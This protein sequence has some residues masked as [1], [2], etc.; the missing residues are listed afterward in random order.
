MHENITFPS[1]QLSITLDFNFFLSPPEKQSF[2][3]I[4]TITYKLMAVSYASCNPLPQ[5]LPPITC[6]LKTVA[7]LLGLRLIAHEMQECY[8]KRRNSHQKSLEVQAEILSKAT[9]NIYRMQLW[10]LSR[11]TSMTIILPSFSF[12]FLSK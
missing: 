11:F 3:T 10:Y 9:E 1:I 8:V 12:F 4:E 2:M 6:N 7:V 5:R